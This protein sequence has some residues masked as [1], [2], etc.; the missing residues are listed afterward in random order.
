MNRRQMLF[1]GCPGSA[2]V[3]VT[4][5]GAFVSDHVPCDGS[6][7]Y[8]GVA[9]APAPDSAELQEMLARHVRD[10]AKLAVIHRELERKSD[11]PLNYNQLR[12][13]LLRET[14]AGAAEGDDNAK[15]IMAVS[16]GDG[17]TLSKWSI[18]RAALDRAH[19]RGTKMTR[20]SKRPRTNGHSA[21]P[22]S[23]QGEPPE[24]S[25]LRSSL[26][27]ITLASA[28]WV[29]PAGFIDAEWSALPGVRPP[30]ATQTPELL[31]F[32]CCS[33]L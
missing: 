8:A 27:V 11:Q 23:R 3:T 6:H 25:P 16:R 1:T 28:H 13:R 12:S 21:P 30:P 33:R 9:L 26:L 24:A 19:S 20:A 2:I 15:F 29:V 7:P 5:Q 18:D 31:S 17:F 22:S 32:E 4:T 10:G 14:L